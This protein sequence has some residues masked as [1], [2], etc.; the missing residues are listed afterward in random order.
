MDFTAETFEEI[1]NRPIS[2]SIFSSIPI[3]QVM[4]CFKEQQIISRNMIH[5]SRNTDSINFENTFTHSEEI[6]SKVISY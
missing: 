6:C 3:T 5:I 1:G 4:L 2:S